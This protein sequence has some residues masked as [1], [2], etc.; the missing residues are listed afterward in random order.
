M[1]EMD[2]LRPSS[3]DQ[4][5]VVIGTTNRPF[6]LDD[7]VLRRLLR[8]LLGETV[9]EDVSL[10]ETARMTGNF[11]GSDLKRAL[12]ICVLD[13]VK[14]GVEGATPVT[15]TAD[16]PSE[17]RARVVVFEDDIDTWDEPLPS[18]DAKPASPET[19]PATPERPPRKALK[20]IT[21]SSSESL[22]TL[23]ELRK[24]ND[25]LSEGKREKRRNMCGKGSFGF[26][27][28]G[29]GQGKIKIA[30]SAG[31]TSTTSGGGGSSAA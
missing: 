21:P 8:R 15:P 11:S 10:D 16:A 23:S 9:A 19:E 3:Q 26:I 31:S 17:D 20:E 2:V 14:A 22:G 4:R 13:A 6:D 18:P 29:E 24:L 5:V 28:K 27:E 30:T 7:A 1:S 12:S 25:E